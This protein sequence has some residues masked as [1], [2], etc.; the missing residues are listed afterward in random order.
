M[1]EILAWL[2]FVLLG[3]VVF[4]IS[5]EGIRTS[6]SD[7]VHSS[8]PMRSAAISSATGQGT[9]VDGD[10]RARHEVE[11]TNVKEDGANTHAAP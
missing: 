4:N 3:A 9:P 5:Q 2:L 11:H 10:F 8:E 7:T 1:R 6:V